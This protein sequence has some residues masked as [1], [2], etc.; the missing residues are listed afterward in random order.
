M[1]KKVVV[2]GSAGP[3]IINY[4]D[5]LPGAQVSPVPGQPAAVDLLTT[6]KN[7]VN[8]LDQY[9]SLADRGVTAL[10]RLDAIIGK[11]AVLRGQAPPQQQQQ[12]PVQ[13]VMEPMEYNRGSPGPATPPPADLPGEPA[14]VITT[15]TPASSQVT[16]VQSAPV[17]QPAAG[18]VPPIAAG[19]S[20]LEI[21]DAL[22]MIDKFQP[23]VTCAQ[24]SESIRHNPAGVQNILNSFMAARK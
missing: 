14:R 12:V 19:V 22:Q 18:P 3:D 8:S 23:G 2:G 10:G 6:T 17:P 24:L 16:S 21:A 5:L 11:V 1:V 13:R 4:R 15:N 9:I 7:A 20:V